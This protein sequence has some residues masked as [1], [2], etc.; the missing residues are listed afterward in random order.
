MATLAVF[1]GSF[2]PPHLGHVAAC[3]L[4]A[5]RPGVDRVVVVPAYS[6][7]FEKALAPFEERFELCRIAFADVA[8]V[9]VSRI[10]ADLG[11]ESRTVRTLEEIRRRAP[12]A[13]L[14]F[15]VGADVLPDWPAWY[16][17]EDIEQMAELVVLG[18]PG[19][20]SPPSAM[21]P[22]PDVS[23]TEVRRRLAAGQPCTDLVP[24]AV[25][26]RISARGLYRA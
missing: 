12:D 22:L 26:A 1:G 4:L 21:R 15:A 2:N 6:H 19:Y 10:E 14:L 11:G 17:H 18:R 16:R 13:K 23:S 5:E 8:R 20:P 25:L 3:R 9:E 24:P 7:P